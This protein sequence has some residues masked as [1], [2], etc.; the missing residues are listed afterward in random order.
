MSGAETQLVLSLTAL[1]TV[2]SLGASEGLA[3]AAAGGMFGLTVVAWR[4]RRPASTALGALFLVHFGLGF[5][6]L[7]PQQ[8]TL[9]LAF[10]CYWALV[11][12]VPWLREAGRWCA[13]GKTDVRSMAFG[14]MFAGI[15]GMAL[16]LWYATAKPDLNDLV[17]TFVPNWTLWLLVPGAVVFS[18]VNAVLEE[19]A[20]RGVVQYSLESATGVG[21]TALVLQA[22]A[23]AALHYQAGFP[24]GVVGVGLTAVYGLVLGAMR[25]RAGG[26]MAPVFTHVLTDLVIVMIVLLL[27]T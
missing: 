24:R 25:R 19:S 12:R 15:S 8:V 26:L 18:L 10:A 20:Y 13:V 2:A 16:L 11:R 22:T 6:G 4:R 21:G 23:F 9:T 1:L 14:A 5:A 27:A 7:G 3:F 17:A